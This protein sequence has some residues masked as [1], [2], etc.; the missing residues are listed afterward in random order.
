M[1]GDFQ[2]QPGLTALQALDTPHSLG[3]LRLQKDLL[4]W[5]GNLPSPGVE[6]QV[7]EQKKRFSSPSGIL[8][9]IAPQ[10]PTNSDNNPAN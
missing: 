2:A 10:D 4:T 9:G 6:Q 8:L 5:P 1:A 3:A 7:C